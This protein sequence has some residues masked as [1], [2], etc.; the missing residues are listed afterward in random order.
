[1]NQDKEAVSTIISLVNIQFSSF[2]IYI[3]VNFYDAFMT[4]HY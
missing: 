2:F 3:I 1:M 4:N